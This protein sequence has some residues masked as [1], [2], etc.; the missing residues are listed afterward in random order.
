MFTIDH[1]GKTFSLVLYL[2]SFICSPGNQPAIPSD[3]LNT[4]RFTNPMNCRLPLELKELVKKGY[5][6]NSGNSNAL[7]NRYKNVYQRRSGATIVRSYSIGF[8]PIGLGNSSL[9]TSNANDYFIN[10]QTST[11]NDVALR[12]NGETGALA[13]SDTIIF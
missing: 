10:F 1:N 9:I 5:T 11:I 4:L 13:P 2:H 12:S 7:I 6:Y 8:T 3:D